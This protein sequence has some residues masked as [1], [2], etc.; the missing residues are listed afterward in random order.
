MNFDDDLD[1]I[2]GK[3][4]SALQGRRS[5]GKD[6]NKS[7]SL[8]DEPSN[9]PPEALMYARKTGKWA[10]DSAKSG[11][12]RFQ[13]EKHESDEDDIPIIPDIEDFQDDSSSPIDD[14]NLVS[15]GFKSTYKELD[16]ELVKIETHQQFVN[17]S[18]ID[19]SLLTS[20]LIPEKDIK[21]N[22]EI[23]TIESLFE[24]VMSFVNT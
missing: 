11:K 19:L 10:E 23:W 22:D 4:V 2:S 14:Q 9:S 17:K 15:H 3:K 24:N 20:K 1:F 16:S 8:D 12:E 13:S 18:K 6:S 5:G 21:E 7:D